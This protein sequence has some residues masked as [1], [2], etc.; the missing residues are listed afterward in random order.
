[1]YFRNPE[2]RQIVTL[3]LSL[4]F[5]IKQ[6][7]TKLEFQLA[8]KRF[9]QLHVI[10]QGSFLTPG[11]VLTPQKWFIVSYVFLSTGLNDLI[12][13]WRWQHKTNARKSWLVCAVANQ[14]E[15][16]AIMMKIATCVCG[17]RSAWR[18]SSLT[19][20][21]TG[22]FLI[23]RQFR[24]GLC[25][26]VI[27]FNCLLDMIDKKARC[28]IVL[29][30]LQDF[31]IDMPR[32][33]GCFVTALPHVGPWFLLCIPTALNNLTVV[34]SSILIWECHLRTCDFAWS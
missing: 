21:L 18:S 14:I 32:I 17:I 7:K 4:I 10:Q 27:A 29:D 13:V 15:K 30:A 31:L 26:Y 16:P 1:M 23:M 22:R 9:A 20:L 11:P 24:L 3:E 6:L 12:M 33:W 28:D 2:G 8:K 19:W 5:C 25:I 34:L